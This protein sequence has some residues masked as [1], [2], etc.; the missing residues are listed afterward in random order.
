METNPPKLNPKPTW[1]EIA[2]G[3]AVLIVISLTVVPRFSQAADRQR[4]EGLSD[5]LQLIR[6]TLD[7]YRADHDGLYPGQRRAGQSV[8]PLAFVQD[9]TTPGCSGQTCYFVR[10]PDNPF[11]GVSDC[12]N[13]VTCVNDPAIRPNGTEGTAWW[14]NAATG[15]FRA[16]DSEFHT[17]Y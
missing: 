17:A 9:I 11:I 2:M 8:S 4:L 13:T 3:V 12:R 15:E 10:F 6:C 14:F 5:T 7:L 16:C 1:F